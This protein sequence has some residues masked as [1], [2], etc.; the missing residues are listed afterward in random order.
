MSKNSEASLIA[1]AAA[2]MAI[3]NYGH[4]VPVDSIRWLLKGTG[5]MQAGYVVCELAGHLMENE[6]HET[7]FVEEAEM[8]VPTVE[9]KGLRNM[10]LTWPR[11]KEWLDLLVE[12]LA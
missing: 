4:P 9:E 8:W 10:H 6:D 5:E 2:A 12:H 11:H 3:S 7:V 1:V